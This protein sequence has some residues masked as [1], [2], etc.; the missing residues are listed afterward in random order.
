MEDPFTCAASKGSNELF[1]DG[2]RAVGALTVEKRAQ[3]KLLP[4]WR[5]RVLELHGQITP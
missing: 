4:L 2:E 1:V 5:T 3:Q